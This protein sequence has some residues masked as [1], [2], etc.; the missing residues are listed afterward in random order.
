MAPEEHELAAASQSPWS[1]WR[2]A[3]T[4]AGL[5]PAVFS[6]GFQQPIPF[7]GHGADCRQHS[8][9]QIP[10]MTDAVWKHPTFLPVQVAWSMLQAKEQNTLIGGQ[11]TTAVTGVDTGTSH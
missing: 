5:A 4:S 3:P 10:G 8:I 7:A 11:K 1:G 9:T 2:K 6:K